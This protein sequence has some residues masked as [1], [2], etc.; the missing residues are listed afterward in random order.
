MPI[1]ATSFKARCLRF[2]DRLIDFLGIGKEQFLFQAY[3]QLTDIL[4]S[5][6]TV[7]MAA[8]MWLP[9]PRMC[10]P[11]TFEPYPADLVDAA[12]FRV[13]ER[14]GTNGNFVEA[15]IKYFERE[16][17]PVINGA[18]SRIGRFFTHADQKHYDPRR[19]VPLLHAMIKEPRFF[20]FAHSTERFVLTLDNISQKIADGKD[21]IEELEFDQY[22]ATL[23]KNEI[24]RLKDS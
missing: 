8:K 21:P 20:H 15:F 4:T 6:S 2:A 16:S 7:R 12:Y 11:V 13:Q 10:V 22:I 3:A 23:I 9:K 18:L 1:V 19:L 24:N 17:I 5:F 14:F